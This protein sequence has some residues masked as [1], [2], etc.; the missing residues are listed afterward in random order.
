MKVNFNEEFWNKANPL[1]K[2]LMIIGSI[3]FDLAMR[4]MGLERLDKELTANDLLGLCACGN[5]KLPES[6]FCKDCI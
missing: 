3:C 6:D 2:L 4:L 1:A 5:D